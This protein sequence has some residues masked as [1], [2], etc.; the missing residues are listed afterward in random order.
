MKSG[1]M[2]TDSAGMLRVLE[3]N[4]SLFLMMLSF[5]FALLGVFIVIKYFH[6]QTILEVTTSRSKIDWSRVFF[7]FGLWSIFTIS[8]V[9]LTYYLSPEEMIWNF[10]PIPFAIL[11][12]IGV[13]LIPIQTST[14]EYVFRGYLMQGFANLSKNKWFPLLMTSVIFGTMHIFN[15]EIDKMGNI[16]LVYYIGTG[17]FLGI[18]TLMDVS[19]TH[20]DVYKRQL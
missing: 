11:V 12:L 17:L 4:L 2:P 7:S 15:P 19:Y 1:T 8:S 5:V 18:I 14:E 6:K 16:V 20:L 13:I 3:S 10:K 9:L